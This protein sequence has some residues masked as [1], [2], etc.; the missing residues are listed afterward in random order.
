ML[1]QG[2]HEF[3]KNCVGAQIA[4]HLERANRT[5][6]TATGMRKIALQ[7]GK[8]EMDGMRRRA[9]RNDIVCTRVTSLVIVMNNKRDA[10]VCA[11]SRI[12]YV[13]EV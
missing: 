10:S 2:Q 5:T 9:K 1:H 12:A 13:P 7:E 8:R 11:R 3:K 4:V 6:E